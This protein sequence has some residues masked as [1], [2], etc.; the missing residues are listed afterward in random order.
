VGI[1]VSDEKKSIIDLVGG[2]PI[3]GVENLKILPCYFC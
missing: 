2:K 1:V 3:G